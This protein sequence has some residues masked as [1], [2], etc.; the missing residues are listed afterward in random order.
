MKVEMRLGKI[1]ADAI[2]HKTIRNIKEI[3]ELVYIEVNG[4]LIAAVSK[5]LLQIWK[6]DNPKIS[7]GCGVFK[8]DT[9][10]KFNI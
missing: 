7:Y 5:N 8:G 2:K 10:I 3:A 9:T 6:C 1:G 4:I